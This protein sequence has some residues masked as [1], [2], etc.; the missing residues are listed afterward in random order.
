ML[1]LLGE[2]LASVE[3]GRMGKGGTPYCCPGC[4]WGGQS[5]LC[6]PQGNGVPAGQVRWWPGRLQKAGGVEAVL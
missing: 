3:L 5:I 4:P 2:K 6:K 1:V